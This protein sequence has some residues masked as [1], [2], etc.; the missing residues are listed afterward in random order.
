MA[1][2][3]QTEIEQ[4]FAAA[5][6][7][8]SGT[9]KIANHASVPEIACDQ[10]VSVLADLWVAVRAAGMSGSEVQAIAERH[11]DWDDQGDPQPLPPGSNVMPLCC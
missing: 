2:S 1:M 11:V 4:I 10:V 9:A 8:A 3:K 6:L 5:V 7:N